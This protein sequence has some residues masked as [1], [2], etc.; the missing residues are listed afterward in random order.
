MIDIDL[1][2]LPLPADAPEP[3]ACIELERPEAGLVIL[4][5]VPPHRSLAV[6]D[7]PL[8]R[9]LAV[10]LNTLSEE[11]GLKGLVITGRTP[12][13]FAAG[14]DGYDYLVTVPLT[15]G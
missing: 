15:K 8:M 1:K 10:V 5:L 7:L 2:G 3:G 11:E 12:D 14:A 13:S 9:D 6:F 4:R